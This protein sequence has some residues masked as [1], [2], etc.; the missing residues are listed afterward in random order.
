MIIP[1]KVIHINLCHHGLSI[2]SLIENF[3]KTPRGEFICEH[4]EDGEFFIEE[5]MDDKFI[6]R[7]AF[8]VN[9]DE[10]YATLYAIKF[11]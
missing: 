1:L 4:M 10:K 3:K 5:W 11:L 6:I 9:I 8:S 7:Q 2:N